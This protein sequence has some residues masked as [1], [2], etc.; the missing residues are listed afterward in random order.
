[1]HALQARERERER[2]APDDA[3]LAAARRAAEEREAELRMAM[4][5]GEAKLRERI[6]RL[7]EDKQDLRRCVRK[8]LDGDESLLG[9][10]WSNLAEQVL[11][12]A[13]AGVIC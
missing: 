6:S 1:M 9:S 13:C 7:D 10:R 4:R 8:R 5:D 11:L 12:C 2:G 3:R